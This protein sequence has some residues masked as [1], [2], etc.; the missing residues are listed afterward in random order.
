[1]DPSVE[2]TQASLQINFVLLPRQAVHSGRGLSLKGKEA[3]PK[4]IDRDVVQEGSEPCA[5]ILACNATHT[6]QSVRRAS[7][8][9]CPGRGRLSGVRLR[10]YLK[11]GILADRPFMDF[12]RRSHGWPGQNVTSHGW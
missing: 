11:I 6:G 10:I 1:M 8:T 5:L 7:P 4:E 9:L 2:I 12:F 3:V